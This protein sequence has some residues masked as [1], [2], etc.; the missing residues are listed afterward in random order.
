MR[1]DFIAIFCHQFD[2]NAGE[3]MQDATIGRSALRFGFAASPVIFAMCEEVI[4]KVNRSTQ[5][6]EGT[7]R[8]PF[9][10]EIFVDASICAESG[11]GDILVGTVEGWGDPRHGLFGPASINEDKTLLE[12][13]W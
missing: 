11:A 13:A 2:A 8:D 5:A 3:L 9:S 4:Q 7:W 6:R 10:S 12:G 1:P